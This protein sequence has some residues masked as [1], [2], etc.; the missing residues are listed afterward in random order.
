[1]KS[2]HELCLELAGILLDLRS[3]VMLGRPLISLRWLLG[4][5][6]ILGEA[7]KSCLLL[8]HR[9]ILSALRL[10]VN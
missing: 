3:I 10:Y 9:S 6:V 7:F 5:M 8:G 2:Y 4:A 1:M